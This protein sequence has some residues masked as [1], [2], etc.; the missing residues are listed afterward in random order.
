MREGA[1]SCGMVEWRSIDL[2]FE[3]SLELEM[4]GG[5]LHFLLFLFIRVS[6]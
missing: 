2:V 4:F 5:V 3:L 6:G 1:G